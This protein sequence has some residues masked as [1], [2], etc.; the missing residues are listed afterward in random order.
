[1]KQTA[2][3][4]DGGFF[5]RRIDHFQRKY[6]QGLNL[7]A[8]HLTQIL[9]RIATQHVQ[10][11]SSPK[12]TQ[13]HTLYRIYFYDCPP[14]TDQI[15][16][17]IPDKGCKTAGT[18]NT[19]K[20]PPYQLRSELHDRLRRNRKTALRL[21]SLSKQGE[22]QLNSPVLKELISGVKVWAD[23]TKDDFHY[24]IAQKMVDTKLGVDITSLAMERL[25]DAI[26]LV[27]GDSD[28]VP[29]AKLAR[30]KGIDFLL[31]PMW[32]TTTH[33]LTEHVDGVRSWDLVSL[34]KA[35]SG[36]DPTLRPSWWK[37]E[38]EE[39]ANDPAIQPAN[40]V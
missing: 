19:K 13:P 32:G 15:R 5:I 28:F 18:W 9:N 39:S 31:D 27:A 7:T 17:P 21:G 11:L 26:V 16:Y 10:N 8:E 22:W 2:I 36:V 4:V 37:A 29:A 24:E 20:H 23:L 38:A 1:M 33:G 12:N 40:M 25:V 35:V 6:F 34:I 30:K 3:L 14:L